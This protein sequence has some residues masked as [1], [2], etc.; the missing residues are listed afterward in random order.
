MRA[1]APLVLTLSLAG[2]AGAA[3]PATSSPS[4]LEVVV[5]PADT[6]AR[7]AAPPREAVSCVSHRTVFPPGSLVGPDSNA[8][9]RSWE[10]SIALDPRGHALAFSERWRGDLVHEETRTMQWRSDKLGRITIDLGDGGPPLL[11]ELTH[12]PHGEPLTQTTTTSG[13]AQTVRYEWRGTFG[14]SG[15]TAKRAPILPRAQSEK[16]PFAPTRLSLPGAPAG[17]LPLSLVEDGPESVGP[18]FLFEGEVEIAGPTG[19]RWVRYDATAHKVFESDPGAPTQGWTFGWEEGRLARA[20]HTKGARIE[21]GW[22]GADLVRVSFPDAGRVEEFPLP[23]FGNKAVLTD[24]L[25]KTIET[26]LGAQCP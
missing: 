8:V 9:E 6:S 19:V 18:P 23:G 5:A 7:P 25:G 10:Q 20:T 2:C 16:L 12:G 1:L 4:P 21:L 24:A 15:R 11:V 22:K 14:S 26:Q 13:R 17:A 3:E